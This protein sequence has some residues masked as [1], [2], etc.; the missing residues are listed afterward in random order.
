MIPGSKYL[1]IIV[2]EG[3]GVVDGRVHRQENPWRLLTINRGQ[4]GLEPLVLGG[5]GRHV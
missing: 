3:K 2:V 1:E 4:L 5:S